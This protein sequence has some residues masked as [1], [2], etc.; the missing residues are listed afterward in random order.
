V[1][2]S[3]KYAALAVSRVVS[4]G[5]IQM[6]KTI[7]QMYRYIY[8]RAERAKKVG[9]FR[10][11]AHQFTA[12]NLRPLLLRERP[13]AVVCTHA[14]PCGAMAEYKRRFSDAPPVVA[15]VT[16]FA[17]HGFWIHRNIDRYVVATPA[18][19]EALLAR[20]VRDEVISVTGIPVRRE[21]TSP[22]EPRD[23]L[24]ERLDLPRDRY[25]ALLMGGGL[26]LAPLEQML[27]SLDAVRA[28]LAAVV[29][30][31]KNARIERR[32]A[33]AAEAVRYPVRTLRF[34][35]NVY[36]YMHAADV[37]VTKSGGLSTSEALLAE[38]PMILCKPLPGQEERNA[39][40]LVE[41][42]AAVRVRGTAELAATLEEILG[43]TERRE[44]MIAV[45]RRL[46]RPHAAHDA[47]SLIARLTTI[48]KEGVA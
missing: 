7:P 29:M 13:D 47:A 12:D 37:L 17:I 24:R 20:R 21:F 1:V 46:A 39:R 36:D 4:D 25:V 11:W 31:G 33:D 16:D 38:I 9:R 19:R 18:M 6:V 48:R 32:L 40:F 2:D 23:Q 22:S 27:L 34:V 10:L 3:Y 8:D 41:A 5:Y 42:G 44:K 15:I 43:D 28:P 26:G 30:A 35:E 14:F 45:G